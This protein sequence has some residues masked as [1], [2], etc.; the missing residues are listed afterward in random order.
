VVKRM[1]VVSSA[2]LC[3]LLLAGCTTKTGPVTG[4][5]AEARDSANPS[6]VR[7]V[8]LHVEGMIERQNIT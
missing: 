7:E 5:A 8:T 2:V 4:P 3:G 6:A 1:A